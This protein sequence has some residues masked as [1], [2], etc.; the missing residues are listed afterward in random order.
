MWKILFSDKAEDD[1]SNAVE[2]ITKILKAPVAAEKLLSDAEKEIGKLEEFP[3]SCPLVK[4][5][6]FSEKGVRFLV[7]NNY[8]VF[9]LL[10]ESE[11]EVSIIRFLYGRRD[12]VSLLE[13]GTED[14]VQKDMEIEK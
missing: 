12:W 5:K 6:Y 1:L 11:K 3:F 9:Y 8:L 13:S 4:D 14:I 2:Y 7:V 10:R